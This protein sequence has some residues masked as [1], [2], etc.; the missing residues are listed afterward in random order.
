MILRDGN[1]A[2]DEV[3]WQTEDGVTIIKII[4]AGQM[5]PYKVGEFV[6]FQ[7]TLLEIR[8]IQWEM[9]D[10]DSIRRIVTVKIHSQV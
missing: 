4:N 3:F 7:D 9:I 1:K 10:Q 6:K 2:Q 8:D 5:H